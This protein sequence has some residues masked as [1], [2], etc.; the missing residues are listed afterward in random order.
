MLTPFVRRFPGL[1]DRET[2]VATFMEGNE[3]S[4][5]KYFFFELYC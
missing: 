4:A 5:G 2:R 1:G 3:I